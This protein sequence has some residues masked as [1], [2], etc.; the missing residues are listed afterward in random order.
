MV[1]IAEIAKLNSM[2]KQ[3]FSMLSKLQSKDKLIIVAGQKESASIELVQLLLG[4]K[5]S[6]EFQIVE[7]MKNQLLLGGVY[8]YLAAKYEKEKEVVILS[9]CDYSAL[10]IKNLKSVTSLSGAKRPTSP[11]TSTKKR[12][13]DIS[14]EAGDK[15]VVAEV[16]TA[17]DMKKDEKAVATHSGAPTKTSRVRLKDLSIESILA[18][19]GALEPYREQMERISGDMLKQAI[20]GATDADSS[21]K[22]KLTMCYGPETGEGIWKVLKKDFQKLKTLAE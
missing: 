16:S 21:F 8:G 2:E 1:I 12:T 20:A 19:Y 9:D 14:A 22:F 7:N 10:P 3:D 5:T 17:A 6:P 13:S 15:A 18:K 11:K 4:L